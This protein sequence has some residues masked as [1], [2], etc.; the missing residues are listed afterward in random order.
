MSQNF[1]QIAEYWKNNYSSKIEVSNKFDIPQHFEK[2]AGLMAPGKSYFYIVNFHTLKLEFISR[3]AEKF[4]GKKNSEVDMNILLSMAHPDDVKNIQLKEKVIQSFYMDYLDKN[5]IADYKLTY[6]YRMKCHKGTERVMLHQATVLSQNEDGR[7]IHVF[8]IHTDIS[9]LLS[10]STKYIS[11][12]NL[13]DGPS[14]YNI[15]T[16][17][18]TFDPARLETGKIKDLLTSRE[19]EIIKQ[20]AMGNSK[21]QISENLNI[22]PHTVHTH[23]RNIL[24]KTNCKN[25][26]HLASV[27]LAEGLISI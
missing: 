4:T 9:H 1:R 20:L 10:N 12:I 15:N 19:I 21:K 5:Q 18:G 13:K 6:T 23:K 7:F 2:M 3:S 22:S 16:E 11:F 8:S 17:F 27:C 24:N 26:T 14:Y 25:S